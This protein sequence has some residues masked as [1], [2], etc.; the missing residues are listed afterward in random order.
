VNVLKTG[1]FGTLFGVTF[2]V[3]A[4][5]QVVMLVVGLLVAVLA[6]TSFT[7]NGQ[8]ATDVGQAI[9]ALV[10][11]FIV[12]MIFNAMI[13]SAGAGLWVLV[14]RVLFKR[15]SPATVF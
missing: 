4:T 7:L 14:R 6:P 15:E 8:K 3:S 2:T 12:G 10:I 13:S 9:G 1:T 5:F 11:M